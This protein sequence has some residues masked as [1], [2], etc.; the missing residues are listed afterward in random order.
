[1]TKTQLQDGCLMIRCPFSAL[2][3]VRLK[4]LLQLVSRCCS[5]CRSLPSVGHRRS[6]SAPAQP[7]A[8]FRNDGG[9]V[10]FSGLAAYHPLPQLHVPD[11]AHS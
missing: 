8:Y 1:M 11:P 10:R 5:D 3:R 4:S 2:M 6:P 9:A 7:G